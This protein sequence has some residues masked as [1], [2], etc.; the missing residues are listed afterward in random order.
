MYHNALPAALILPFP[1]SD[2]GTVAD[3]QARRLAVLALPGLC[4][5]LRTGNNARFMDV[6]GQENAI[7][8]VGCQASGAKPMMELVLVYLVLPAALTLALLVLMAKR[9]PRWKGNPWLY[10]AGFAFLAGLLS[11]TLLMGG[12]GGLPGPTIGGLVMVLTRLE[13][14]G[15]LRA[16]FIGFGSKDFGFLSAPFLV[17]F[18][19]TMFVPLRTARPAHF[20]FAD[21]SD[22]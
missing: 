15:D 4:L 16:S 5:C 13:W 10:R 9:A 18:A 1:G 11:P 7:D 3:R 22:G 8:D 21:D 12:H 6:M 19:L 2:A 17:V 20:G 14:I